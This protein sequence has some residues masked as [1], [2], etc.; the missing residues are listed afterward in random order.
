MTALF[1]VVL[2][3]AW[4]AVF[5]PSALRAWQRTPLS[6]AERFRRRMQL[7][8]PPAVRGRWVVIPEP[9]DRLAEA[10]FRRGRLLRRRIFT[11][12]IWSVVASNLIAILVGGSMWDVSLALDSSLALYVALLLETKRRV[13]ERSRLVWVPAN[14]AGRRQEPARG[15][16][17][18]HI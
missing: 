1:L 9:P 6:T 15:Y 7:L 10:S 2:A 5:F 16:E 3:L 8:A 12:L 4:A 13:E 14:A 11:F 17:M 18:R